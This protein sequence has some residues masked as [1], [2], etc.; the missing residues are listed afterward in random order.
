MVSGARPLTW[1]RVTLS[2]IYLF[3]HNIYIEL[4]DMIDGRD[5]PHKN[6]TPALAA[7]GNLTLRDL[8]EMF[9]GWQMAALVAHDEIE[10]VPISRK[11]VDFLSAY[12]VPFSG[13][14]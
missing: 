12:F 9:S 6:L 4:S 13:R 3:Y 10:L 7:I 5:T 14:T 11:T 1:V 2:F 8:E